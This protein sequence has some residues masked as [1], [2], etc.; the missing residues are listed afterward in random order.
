MRSIWTRIATFGVAGVI[1]LGTVA[2]ASAATHHKRHAAPVAPATQDEIVGSDV[3]LAP[4]NNWSAVPP[5]SWQGPYGCVT[6]EGYGR[7]GSCDAG[8]GS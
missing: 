1:A 5:S 7:Y 3:Q 2:S 8:G 4:R 6:D